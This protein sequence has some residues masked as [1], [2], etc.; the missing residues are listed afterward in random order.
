VLLLVNRNSGTGCGS[1]IVD[2]LLHEL[3]EACGWPEELDVDVVDDHPAARLAAR[4]FLAASRQPAAVIVGGGGGTLRAA[5][6]G[7]LDGAGDGP[8]ST[9]QV[10]LGAL[11]MGSGNLV[12][13]RF[14]VPSDPRQGMHD[15][16][17]SLR[18][19]R[20]APCGVIRCRFGTAAGGEDVRH[21]VTM[22]GLGQFG[23]AP[24]D[25]A[26]WHRRLGRPRRVLAALAG[27]ERL[28]NLEYLTSV[29]GRLLGATAYGRACE[30]VEIS[31]GE[32]RE[33]FRLL[34][35]AVM[36]LRVGAIPMDPHVT[37]QEPAAGVMLLPRGGRPRIW[38]LGL[39]EQLRLTLLDRDS[40]EFFLDEDPERAYGG[41]TVEMVGTLAFMPGSAYRDVA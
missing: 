40:V 3:H 19:N 38:R 4:R 26:R 17:A 22:C 39:G 9:W 20:T 15:L 28:N 27:I 8:M 37:I 32:R 24:G 30:R 12:A 31:L 33:R 23:R 18:D 34:A 13:R 35:G 11:R 16:A 5:V 21:A 29:S 41:L 36:K 6:E 25:L 10:R 7:V 2:E 14:G 1:R